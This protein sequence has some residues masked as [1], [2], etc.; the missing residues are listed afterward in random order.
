MAACFMAA[1]KA[2]SPVE[3]GRR[4]E[5]AMPI[6]ASAGAAQSQRC[7]G[8]GRS[9]VSCRAAL[10]SCAVWASRWRCCSAVLCGNCSNHHAAAKASLRFCV[11]SQSASASYLPGLLRNAPNA[12]PPSQAIKASTGSH[13]PTSVNQRSSVT[14]AKAATAGHNVSARSRSQRRSSTRVCTRAAT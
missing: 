6:K 13:G 3:S 5:T 12:V 1:S 7:S 2:M 4:A 10:P 11:W 14:I 8:K 9:F